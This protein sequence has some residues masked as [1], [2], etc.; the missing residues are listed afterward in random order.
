MRLS[1]LSF[2]C[3]LMLSSLGSVIA[4]SDVYIQINHKLDTDPFDFSVE[5]TNN[6]GD[7]FNVTRLEYYMSSITITH[8]GGIE[9]VVPETWILANAGTFTNVYLGSFDITTLESVSF[10]IGVEGDYNH[11]DPASYPSEHPLAPKSPSMHWG[12]SPGY[13]FVAMEG[14]GGWFNPDL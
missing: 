2:L 11:L 8:D 6:L 12:W 13:R 4:Q 10:G 9:T 14:S 7:E 1:V 5:H 3:A